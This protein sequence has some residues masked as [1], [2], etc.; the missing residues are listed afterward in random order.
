MI[1][2]HYFPFIEA[3]LERKIYCHCYGKGVLEIK[4]P[5]IIVYIKKK[6]DSFV[7]LLVH[8]KE[9]TT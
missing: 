7:V 6:R 5:Y 4:C 2:K 3:S 8:L 9:V 1:V